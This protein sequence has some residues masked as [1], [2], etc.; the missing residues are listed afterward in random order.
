MALLLW[1]PVLVPLLPT[2]LRQ[3]TIQSYN[4]IASMAALVGLY[5]AVIIL[6]AIWGRKIR[7]YTNP[8]GQYGIK[9]QPMLEQVCFHTKL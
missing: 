4:G 8:L 5:G 2:L 7:G 3:W 1:S 6:V 9:L